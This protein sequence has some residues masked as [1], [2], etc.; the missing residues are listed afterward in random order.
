MSFSRIFLSTEEVS[1]SFSQAAGQYDELSSLHQQ[2]ARSLIQEV[3]DSKKPA[4]HILDI[5]CGT[6]Y[7][8][9]QARQRFAQAQ[10]TGLDFSPGMITQAQTN[11][12][13]I[14]FI[15]ADARQMPLADQ[16]FDVVFSNFAFQWMPELLEAFGEAHRV[17]KDGGLLQATL[18]GERTCE[19]LFNSLERAGFDT[20]Y[21]NR[22]VDVYQIEARL[23]KAGFS[24]IVVEQQMVK[25]PFKDL[26][27]LLAWLKGLGANKLSR[28]AFIGPRTLQRANAYCLKNRLDDQNIGISFEVIKLKAIR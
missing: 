14:N 1:R 27:Q 15:L 9:A 20:D 6:G 23:R 26:W 12:K 25:L 11:Y 28:R 10:V 17:L 5:G 19:E 4:T 18:F 21:L 22:F 13:D 24:Q 3:D 7:L 16:S 2:F 8:S